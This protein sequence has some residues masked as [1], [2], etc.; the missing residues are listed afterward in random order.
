MSTAL[1]SSVD[2]VVVGSG[3]VVFCTGLA[4]AEHGVSAL[5]LERAPEEEARGHPFHRRCF[6]LGL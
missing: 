3:N 4:A 6:S 5:M 1:P 2:V